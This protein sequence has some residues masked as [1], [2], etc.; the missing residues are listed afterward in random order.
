MPV[1][2]NLCARVVSI[3]APLKNDLTLHR[4]NFIRANAMYGIPNINNLQFA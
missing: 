4:S 2:K 3:N 1:T